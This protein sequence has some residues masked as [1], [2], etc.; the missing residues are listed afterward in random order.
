[1]NKQQIERILQERGITGEWRGDTFFIP[2]PFASSSVVF[3]SH[4]KNEATIRAIPELATVV[5]SIFSSLHFAT[6]DYTCVWCELDEVT[7]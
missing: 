1:M 2:L 4:H 6:G 3:E 7:R 5:R